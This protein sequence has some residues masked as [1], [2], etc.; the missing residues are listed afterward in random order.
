MLFC[1][2]QMSFLEIQRAEEAAQRKRGQTP[3]GAAASSPWSAAAAKGVKQH[4]VVMHDTASAAVSTSRS[5]APVSQGSVVPHATDSGSVAEGWTVVPKKEA[6]ISP[7]SS[8]T[9]TS[10][11]IVGMPIT[12]SV[13]A[14]TP[15]KKKQQQTKTE[16]SDESF[17]DYEPSHAA[18]VASKGMGGAGSIQSS[19][20]KP[21]SVSPKD[22]FH[23]WC[24]RELQEFA[25]I[26]DVST[27]VMFLQD[28]PDDEVQEYVKVS[29]LLRTVS[30]VFGGRLTSRWFSSG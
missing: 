7:S 11:G 22:S 4:G 17:W 8:S 24:E 20:S 6:R 28:L 14:T 13:G 29:L 25:S 26:F 21:A 5:S 12:P 10:G 27:F 16:V 2:S 23:Q 9:S 19:A 18:S 3:K 15:G 30:M 1:K